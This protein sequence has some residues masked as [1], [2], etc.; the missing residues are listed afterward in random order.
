MKNILLIIAM[1]LAI[2]ATAS[3]QIIL[4]KAVVS[5]AG[6]T[7]VNGTIALQ[8]TVS[9]PVVGVASNGKTIGQFGFWSVE[10]GVAGVHA[11]LAAGPVNSITVFPNPAQGQVKIDLT[12]TASGSVDLALYDDGGRLIR[13]IY[14]GKNS[15]GTTSYRFDASG[16]ASGSYFIA[17]SMPGALVQTKLTIIK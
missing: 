14:S 3:A 8:Y 17:A 15:T 1:L 2:A 13:S 16:L 9:Q 11:S 7:A 4:E 10:N 12:T 5:Q 6:G